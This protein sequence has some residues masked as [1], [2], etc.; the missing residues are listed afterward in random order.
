MTYSLSQLFVLRGHMTE[1]QR[2]AN[3]LAEAEAARAYVPTAD[4]ALMEA[5]LFGRQFSQ[6]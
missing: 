4:E 6:I 2:A 3:I 1:A 5:V